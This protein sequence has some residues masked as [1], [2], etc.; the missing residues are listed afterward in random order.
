MKESRLKHFKD[1]LAEM[2]GQTAG[3]YERTVESS[4]EEFAGS[5]LPDPNDEATR[6]MNRRL[7]LSIS[8]RSHTVLARIGAALERIDEGEYGECTDCGEDIPEGRL[9]LVPYTERCVACQEKIE[10]EEK[11]NG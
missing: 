2:E 9:D 5:E 7:L 6:T 10:V 8:E 4:G 3:D 1:I 11:E